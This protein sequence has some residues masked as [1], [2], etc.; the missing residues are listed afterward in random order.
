M[1][2][3]STSATPSPTLSAALALRAKN[4]SNMLSFADLRTKRETDRKVNNALFLEEVG[5][6]DHVALSTLLTPM[7]RGL[8]FKL[9]WVN[10]TNVLVT[11][12]TSG[13]TTMANELESR[14]NLIQISLRHKLDQTRFCAA[15]ETVAYSPIDGK[16][17]RGSWTPVLGSNR[18]A[19]GGRGG[20]NGTNAKL[21]ST[22]AFA[23]LGAT[24]GAAAAAN[25]G[26]VGKRSWGS[27]LSGGMNKVSRNP[28]SFIFSRF[29]AIQT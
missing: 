10:E 23:A 14:L 18:S 12:E 3:Q 1:T 6:Y 20:G 28:F 26:E 8:L 24:S 27:V 5:G 21:Y 9:E 15:V 2:R 13:T 16:I 4:G 22:N 17:T 29:A 7:M 25:N 11:F 19:A